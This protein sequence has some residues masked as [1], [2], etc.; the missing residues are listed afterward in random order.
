V[1]SWFQAFCFTQGIEIPIYLLAWRVAHR[2]RPG[3]VRGVGVAFVASLMTHPF[4][5]AVFPL[6]PRAWGC[7]GSIRCWQESVVLAEIFAVVVEA[8][9]LGRQGVRQ[10]WAWSLVA[11]GASFGLGALLHW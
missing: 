9:W 2:W 5:W 6:V 7:V 8:V 3:L 10:A 1:L 11:N 4:V